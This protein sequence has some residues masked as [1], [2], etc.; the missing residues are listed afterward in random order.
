[1]TRIKSPTER[2]R[3]ELLDGEI[4]YTLKEA[5]IVIESWR[6][7]FV[8]NDQGHSNVFFNERELTLDLGKLCIVDQRERSFARVAQFH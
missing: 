6:R 8:V 2:L 4:F 5:Q 7:H 1:L 3:D